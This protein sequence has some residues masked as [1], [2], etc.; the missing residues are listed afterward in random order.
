MW[1]RRAA[2][3]SHSK[4]T[5]GSQLSGK[6]IPEA[7][8]TLEVTDL[9]HSEVIPG[10]QQENLWHQFPQLKCVVV[11]VCVRAFT[12]GASDRLEKSRNNLGF[13]L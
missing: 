1:H 2:T 6:L 10:G 11:C 5:A 3:V 12:H 13:G 8:R 7:S 4:V 9:H